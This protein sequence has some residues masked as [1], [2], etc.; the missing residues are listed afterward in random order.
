[1][2]I[3]DSVY[4]DGTINGNINS[5]GSSSFN[6]INTTGAANIGGILSVGTINA[7]TINGNVSVN[8]N[9]YVKNNLTVGT[10]YASNLVGNVTITNATFPTVTATTYIGN[11]TATS[12][13]GISYFNG[14]VGIGTSQPLYPFHIT[15]FSPSVLLSGSISAGKT[16]ISY[17]TASTS[18]TTSSSILRTNTMP[19]N[20]WSMVTS[21]CIAG[22]SIYAYSDER[23]KTNIT[24]IND[25][26]ALSVLRQF[27]PKQ[28][29]YIDTV[30][31][32]S[33][34]VWGF[35]AQ[36]VNDVL[37]YAVTES[38]DV[39]PNIYDVAT[40]VGNTIQLQNVSTNVIQYSDGSGTTYYDANGNLPIRIIDSNDNDIIV[41]ISSIVDDNTFEITETLTDISGCF[42]YGQQVP[43]FMNIDKNAIYTIA[44]S[45]LQEVD[46]ELQQANQTIQSMQQ[47][48]QQ[49]A[50]I[51][52][53]QTEQINTIMQILQRNNIQ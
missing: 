35:I 30:Q 2:C 9:L 39:I 40:V 17:L 52:Q 22:T 12:T 15:K 33:S 7:S 53:Q 23:I 32:G 34:K 19:T 20:T 10:V 26:T 14:N 36:E 50:Q 43:N 16:Y 42:V 49:Q 1:M 13:T 27:K 31:R 44:V 37:D 28:Y 48:I 3:R 29:N 47:T 4:T 38:T 8:A 45:A 46:A 5:P 25:V 18:N 11:L 41:F 21:G 24:D 51:I 6:I